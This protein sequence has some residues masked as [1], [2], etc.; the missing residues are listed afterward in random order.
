M[1][2]FISLQSGNEGASGTISAG[3]VTYTKDDDG[4]E[5]YRM[6]EIAGSVR[7]D[8]VY[9]VVQDKLG[10]DT[11]TR[12]VSDDS[13]DV[14]AVGTL[15]QNEKKEEMARIASE[16]EQEVRAKKRAAAKAASDRRKARNAAVE[17][18]AAVKQRRVTKKQ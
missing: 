12:L 6:S 5:T 16:K 13:A 15:K 1:R 10:N 17:E 7:S 2:P 18:Q 9:D 3:V 11:P 4:N 8:H 14:Y